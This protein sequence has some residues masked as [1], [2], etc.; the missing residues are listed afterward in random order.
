MDFSVACFTHSWLVFHFF[1]YLS[2]SLSR[3]SVFFIDS[4]CAF[5][6]AWIMTFVIFAR[7]KLIR[8]GFAGQCQHSNFQ[9]TKL[10][11]VSNESNWMQYT[12]YSWQI[13]VCIIEM[14]DSAYNLY[15]SKFNEFNAKTTKTTKQYIGER[16]KR[17]RKW[18]TLGIRSECVSR[19]R[20]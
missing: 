10:Q 9:S 18:H 20:W 15:H 12:Q 11:N 4:P 7:A 1:L 14:V 16:W 17:I 6:S 3:C 19:M 5:F 13:Q 2:F 8:S